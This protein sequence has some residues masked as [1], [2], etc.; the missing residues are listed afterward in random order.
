[1]AEQ[2]YREFL[3]SIPMDGKI[4]LEAVQDYLDQAHRNTEI[5]QRVDVRSVLDYSVL[6]EV[7][8]ER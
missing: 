8:K 1:V 6:D 2:T 5:P 4:S 7:L 3:P